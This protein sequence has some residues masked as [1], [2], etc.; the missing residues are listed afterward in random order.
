M[1]TSN[2]NSIYCVHGDVNHNIL[3]FC[4]NRLGT[5][6]GTSLAVLSN[7]EGAILEGFDSLIGFTFLLA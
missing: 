7:Q 2:V 3:R 1:A 4:G 5:I 6:G